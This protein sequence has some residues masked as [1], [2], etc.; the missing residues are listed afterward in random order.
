MT[1]A[2]CGLLKL[3]ASP[4]KSAICR[5][6]A[7]FGTPQACTRRLAKSRVAGCAAV[8]APTKIRTSAFFPATSSYPG[9]PWLNSNPKTATPST[10]E[11]A[12]VAE[13][14]LP[15]AASRTVYVP[16]SEARK[17]GESVVRALSL[18]VIS[19]AVRNSVQLATRSGDGHVV[20]RRL[21][22]SLHPPRGNPT[23]GCSPHAGRRQST[24]L[25]P[26]SN[27]PCVQRASACPW[28]IARTPLL[29]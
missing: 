17:S 28:S 2:S 26:R 13:A 27:R 29:R 24:A 18:D 3:D 1:R 21:G 4:E 7:N 22:E 12:I 25:T 5:Q 15:P 10:P 20:P 16:S 14:V 19:T 8:G 9:S 11:T 23:C 6:D